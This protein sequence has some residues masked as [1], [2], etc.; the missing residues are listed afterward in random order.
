MMPVIKY[1]SGTDGQTVQPGATNSRIIKKNTDYTEPEHKMNILT[2]DIIYRY[3]KA[4]T[5]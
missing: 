1:P 2:A 3:A 5:Q 4:K